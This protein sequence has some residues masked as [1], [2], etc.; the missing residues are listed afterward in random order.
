MIAVAIRSIS[1]RRC[2]GLSESAGSPP[3]SSVIVKLICSNASSLRAFRR[4][5]D[6]STTRLVARPSGRNGRRPCKLGQRPEGGDIE[7]RDRRDPNRSRIGPEH[8]RRNLQIAS[9]DP[10]NGH[11]AVDVSC[12]GDDLERLTRERMKRVVDDDCRT[13]GL[14]SYYV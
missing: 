13:M 4:A 5:K 3:R 12:L 1:L 6:D 14:V 7:R 11:C 8:P 9:I 2:S 10:V